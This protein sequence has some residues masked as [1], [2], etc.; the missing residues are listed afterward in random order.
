[1]I[2]IAV[3]ITCFNRKQKT[4]VC[5]EKLYAQYGFNKSYHVHTYLL[6]DA[7][8]DG[9]SY[10]VKELFPDVNISI[11]NG[12]LFWN[13]GMHLAWKEACNIGIYDFFLWL[14]DDTELKL[15]AIETL[16]YSSKK[17]FN[18]AIIVGA[19]GSKFDSR[20]ITY[21]G[22]MKNGSLI[23]PSERAQLC[24]HFN[25]NIVLVPKNVFNVLGTNDPKFHHSLGDFDY[26]LRAKKMGFD[27]YLAPGILGFCETHESLPIWCDPKKRFFQRWKSFRTPLGH[28]P[29]EY[30]YFELRH[31]G[32]FWAVF[33][34]FTNHLRLIYPSLWLKKKYN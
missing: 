9:T 31:K 23:Y 16:I 8:I 19:T 6:D 10:A 3:L 26:G 25:G 5:L 18:N 14:N 12:N 30:F 34:Y 21:G 7:S 1:M 15:S 24:D 22:R 33:H 17:F 27:I 32:I 2:N 4:L 11:G 29:E 13:R 28:N 20:K